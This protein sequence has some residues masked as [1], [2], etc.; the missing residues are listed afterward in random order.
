MNNFYKLL[1]TACLAASITACNDN[2]DNKPKAPRPVKSIVLGDKQSIVE[3]HFPGKV[4]A[5]KRAELSFEVPGKLTKLPIKKGQEVRKGALLAQLDQVPFEDKVQTTQASFDY[6]KLQYRRGKELVK[7]NYISKAE[8]DKL[9]STYQISEAR[10]STAKRDL[11]QSTLRAPFEGVVADRYVENHEQV[12]A[13]QVLMSFHDVEYLDIET[14]VP[15]KFILRIKEAERDPNAADR[16]TAFV[17]FDAY[18]DKKYPLTFKEYAAQ[19]DDDTQTYGIIFNMKQPDNIN[20]LPGMS[21]NVHLNIS[22]KHYDY[23]E[24][25]NLPVSAVFTDT[26]QQSFVWIVTKE[27][28]VKKQAVKMTQLQN[29]SVEITSGLQPG[30]RVV[31]AGVHYLRDNQKVTLPKDN[32]LE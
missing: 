1:L 26:N 14:H 23:D 9:H 25:Y 5:S 29:S 32:D 12:K 17:I 15:E 3:R 22:S 24:Y 18:P 6:A 7:G 31:I 11:Q 13:K 19:S 27:M 21:V 20:V 10:L 2:N 28:T 16:P 8:F 30:D 4:L